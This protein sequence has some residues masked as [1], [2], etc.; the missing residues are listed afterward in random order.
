[1]ST[2]STTNETARATEQDSDD[3]QESKAA[4]ERR[5]YFYEHHRPP[6]GYEAEVVGD[7]LEIRKIAER[8]A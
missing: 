8:P 3:T 4:Q 6:S 1:M 7:R 2:K 5:D